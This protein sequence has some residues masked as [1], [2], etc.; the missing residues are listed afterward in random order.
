MCMFPSLQPD[1]NVFTS[2]CPMIYIRIFSNYLH[3]DKFL[4]PWR[5][6]FI[7]VVKNIYLHGDHSITYGYK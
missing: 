1:G 3:G 5:K 4:S 6:I 2:V 7:T